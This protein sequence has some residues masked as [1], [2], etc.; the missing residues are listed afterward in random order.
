MA[1][2][3]KQVR[4]VVL[5]DDETDKFLRLEAAK[6]K[7]RKASILG[8]AFF[9]AIKKRDPRALQIVDEYTDKK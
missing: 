6:D 2:T 4:I 1:N 3:N 9:K 7:K 5:V 8:R